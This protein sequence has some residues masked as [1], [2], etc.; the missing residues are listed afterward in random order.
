MLSD[1]EIGRLA[2]AINALRPDWPIASLATLI[3]TKLAHRPRRDI[4]VA[5][6]WVACESASDKPA[7]VLEAGPWW[8]AVA[9]DGKAFNGPPRRE[10]DCPKHPGHWAQRCTACAADALAGDASTFNPRRT[11]AD[12][13]ALAAARAELRRVRDQQTSGTEPEETA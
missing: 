4:A 1:N 5:L 13:E 10:E 2:G 6:A 11:P 3:R 7:R 8:K 12:P 9:V